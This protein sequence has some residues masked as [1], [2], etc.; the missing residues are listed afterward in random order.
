MYFNKNRMTLHSE[1]GQKDNVGRNP[2]SRDGNS[3]YF[4]IIVAT[5]RAIS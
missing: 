4:V 3:G 1:P 5:G 2:G